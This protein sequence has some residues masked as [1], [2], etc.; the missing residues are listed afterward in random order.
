MPDSGSHIGAEQA[1]S[2][3]LGRSCQGNSVL[4]IDWVLHDV[5]G[6]FWI[7]KKVVAELAG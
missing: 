2:E 6:I 4:G 3:V 5:G 1:S 7:R